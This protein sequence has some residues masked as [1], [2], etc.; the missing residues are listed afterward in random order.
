LGG[1]PDDGEYFWT[2]SNIDN[3]TEYEW[4]D[5]LN[6][7]TLYTFPN[8]DQS[9]GWLPLEFNFPFYTDDI[10][11]NYYSQLFINPN[12]WVGFDWDDTSWENT[13]IPSQFLG[14]AIFAL[15]DDLNPVNEECNQYCAGNVYYHSSEE[16]FVVWF[17]Q[18][19]HWNTNFPNTSYDFQVVLYPSGKIDLN[20]RSLVGDYDASVGIQKNGSIGTQVIYGTDDLENNLNIIFASSPDWLSINPEQGTL[21]DG[22]SESISIICNSSSYN[23]GLYNAFV[24]IA[25]NGGNLSVPVEMMINGSLLGDTNGDSIINVLDVIIMVNMILGETDIDLNTADINGDGLV[26]VSDIVLL[27]NTILG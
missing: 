3:D 22:E 14:A 18:V 5:I 12:G 13:S 15:W 11:N 9:G 19:A 26:N 6:I 21:M 27:I 17:D 24:N 2:D 7:G 20:Y 1:G 16:K 23:D 25:S 8:N 10:S 4:I